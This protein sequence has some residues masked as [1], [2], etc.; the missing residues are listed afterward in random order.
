M[1]FA[2]A[3]SGRTPA[4]HPP[5]LPPCT[6]PGSRRVCNV[7]KPSEMIK[8]GNS[9]Y[10]T[11]SAPE[12]NDAMEMAAMN[13][14]SGRCSH[15][16]RAYLVRPWRP[17]LSDLRG[18]QGGRSFAGCLSIRFSPARGIPNDKDASKVGDSGKNPPLTHLRASISLRSRFSHT[19]TDRSTPRIPGVPLDLSGRR[20]RSEYTWGIDC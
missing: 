2:A 7:F 15:A 3:L 8:Y 1:R 20:C 11:T 18:E 6:L 16:F 13:K 17:R 10:L 19:Y 5:N 14:R 4:N 12:A 9:L